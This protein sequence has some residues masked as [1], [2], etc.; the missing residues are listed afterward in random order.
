MKSVFSVF[1]YLKN[2]RTHCR[3]RSRNLIVPEIR[4][5]P[6][7]PPILSLFFVCPILFRLPDNIL[8]NGDFLG[9]CKRLTNEQILDVLP[10]EQ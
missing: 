5:A 2:S 8:E 3:L 9:S 6:N 4:H 7:C 1:A 10:K